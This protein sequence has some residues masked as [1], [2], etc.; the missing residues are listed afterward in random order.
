MKR[1]FY[2]YSVIL[3]LILFLFTGTGEEFKEASF[4]ECSMETENISAFRY[5]LYEPSSPVPGMPLIVYL[6]GRSGKG[7]E[8]RLITSV[9]GFPEY[10]ESGKL[11]SLPAYVLIPQLPSSVSGWIKA[12]GD[13]DELVEAVVAEYEIDRDNISLTGHSMGGSGVWKFA[14]R[15]SGLYSRFAPL[16]GSVVF[17]AENVERLKDKEIWA[18]VGAL[19]TVVPPSSS[20]AM[21]SAIEEAGGNAEITIFD[22]ADHFAVPGLAYLGDTPLIEWLTGN[23]SF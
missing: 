7:E 1:R 3:V 5:W 6:H 12:A 18:F 22:D 21:V 8:L 14:L 15:N 9:N 2:L 4:S 11:G 19:D 17:R 20:T 13:V 10:V 23:S 16:S